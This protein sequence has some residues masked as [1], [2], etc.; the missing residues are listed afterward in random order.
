MVRRKKKKKKKKKEKK[1]RKR[2]NGEKNPRTQRISR[3]CAVDA[4]RKTETKVREHDILAV[5]RS[6]VHAVCPSTG[7]RVRD[8]PN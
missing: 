8:H 5:K 4:Q 1:K 6:C 7:E 2:Y 3:R